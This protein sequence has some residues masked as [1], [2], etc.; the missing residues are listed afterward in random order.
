MQGRVFGENKFL[1]KFLD[2]EN[3]LSESEVA[4]SPLQKKKKKL[5]SDKF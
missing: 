3:L 2:V 5:H 1:I 4:A